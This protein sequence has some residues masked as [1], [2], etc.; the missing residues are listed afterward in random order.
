MPGIGRQG[1]FIRTPVIPGRP[2]GA[3]REGGCVG[4]SVSQIREI[5]R[6]G[7]ARGKPVYRDHGRHNDQSTTVG[8]VL[9]AYTQLKPGTKDE[10]LYAELHAHGETYESTALERD[11]R[12]GVLSAVSPGYRTGVGAEAWYKKLDEISLTS[13]KNARIPGALISV[14]CSEPG[15][16]G[17]AGAC[18]RAHVYA[19]ARESFRVAPARN[20]H[21]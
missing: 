8:T 5:A 3:W 16:S 10:W 1:L 19:V 9:N 7:E 18:A 20:A 14:Y 6:S 12:A 2:D 17:G 21:L 11:V 15:A 4:F 13:A